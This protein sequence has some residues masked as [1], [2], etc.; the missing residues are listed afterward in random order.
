MNILVAILTDKWAEVAVKKEL[1]ALREVATVIQEKDLLDHALSA[2]GRG[3][4]EAETSLQSFIHLVRICPV[5][6]LQE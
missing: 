6:H 3:Q 5:H 4:D 2:E 1:Y